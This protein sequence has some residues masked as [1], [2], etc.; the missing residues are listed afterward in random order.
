MLHFDF[1]SYILRKISCLS[2]GA[3]TLSHPQYFYRPFVMA[4]KGTRPADHA[5]SWY[6]SDPEALSDELDD[7]LGDVPET[8]NDSHL[9]IPNARAIIAP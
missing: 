9:P 5:G 3:T 6:T 1:A 4:L 7:W 2:P 8:I